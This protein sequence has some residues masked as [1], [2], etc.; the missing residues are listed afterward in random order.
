[1]TSHDGEYPD[2]HVSSQIL[3][4]KMHRDNLN[5]NREAIIKLLQHHGSTK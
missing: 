2:T 3:D 4:H 1:M 5:K